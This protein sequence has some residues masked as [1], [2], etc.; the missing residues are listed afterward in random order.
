MS[1]IRVMLIDDDL[2]FLEETREMFE[3]AGYEMLAIS[4]VEGAVEAIAEFSPH[5]LLLDM[6]MNGNG[7]KLT[8]TLRENTGTEKLPVVII[9][10]YMDEE[11]ERKFREELD[12]DD[13]LEK[14]VNPLDLIA[15]VER[16]VD[17]RI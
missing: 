15:T 16:V 5:I 7:K 8:A 1:G 4:K 10:A 13:I 6:K 2:E 11:S 14:P 17:G 12:V 9:S 3:E